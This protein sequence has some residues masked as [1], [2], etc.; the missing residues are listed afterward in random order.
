VK[1][2]R[3]ST[4]DSH[5]PEGMNMEK[6]PQDIK[7]ENTRTPESIPL[8]EDVFFVTLHESMENRMVESPTE[9]HKSVIKQSQQAL[10]K[11]NGHSLNATDSIK[12]ENQP[13]MINLSSDIIEAGNTSKSISPHKKEHGQSVTPENEEG[14]SDYMD[15]GDEATVDDEEML[16]TS[17][18]ACLKDHDCKR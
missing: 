9:R 18:S 14:F 2:P 6:G 5:P 4:K 12:A 10:T 13:D 7:K 11:K 16:A 8:H 17:T 15:G 3:N 1:N